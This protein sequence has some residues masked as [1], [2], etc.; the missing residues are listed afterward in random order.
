MQTIVKNFRGIQEA[1]ITINQIAGNQ[2]IIDALDET[3]VRKKKLAQCLEAFTSSYIEPLCVDF[4]I[5]AVAIDADINV[6]MGDTTYPMLSASEQFRVRTVLQL[7]IAMLE[8]SALVIIDGADIL[9]K[10]GR[11]KLLTMLVNSKMPALICMTL[12]NPTQAPD[13]AKAGVGATYW[14]EGGICKPIASAE[15]SQK[16]A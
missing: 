9:D 13:L 5:P 8:K 7:A 12:N 16:A 3:G 11:G 10:G 2:K 15:I 1:H 6:K 4:G 14:I